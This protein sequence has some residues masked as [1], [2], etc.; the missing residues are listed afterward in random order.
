[1]AERVA[2]EFLPGWVQVTVSCWGRVFLVSQQEAPAELMLDLMRYQLMVVGGRGL[3]HLYNMQPAAPHW[4]A[5][6]G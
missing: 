6:Y 5:A 1:M 4:R 2:K 3:W